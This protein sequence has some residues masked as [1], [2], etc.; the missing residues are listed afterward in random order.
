MPNGYLKKF[1]TCCDPLSDTSTAPRATLHLKDT[2]ANQARQARK[3]LCPPNVLFLFLNGLRNSL[4]VAA[5]PRAL[6][7]IRPGIQDTRYL[8]AASPSQTG[9]E[10]ELEAAQ[11]QHWPGQGNFLSRN[12]AVIASP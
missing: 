10:I 9:L 7:L 1:I 8:F 3:V 4:A 11:A 6:I 5:G 12:L 2:R